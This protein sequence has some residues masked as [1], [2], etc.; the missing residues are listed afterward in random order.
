M[1]HP[2]FLLPLSLLLVHTCAR[3]DYHPT[4]NS[5]QTVSGD[6]VDGHLGNQHVYGTLT[7]STITGSNAY[8]Y[9]ASGGQTDNITVTHQGTLFLEPGGYADHTSV[10]SGGQLQINGSAE[11]AYV[12]N[13]GEIYINAG[14]NG[15]NDPAQGGQALNTTIGSGGVMVNR[16]GVDSFTVVEAGGELDTGWNEPYEIRDIA[17]SQNATIK[18][19]GMQQVTNGGTSESSLVE[20]GSTL[21]VSGIW[22]YDSVLDPAPS[23]WYYGTANGSVIYGEMQNLGGVDTSTTLQSGGKYLLDNY[24]VSRKLTVAQGG[25]AQINHGSLND[26][27]LYGLMNVSDD[28]ILTGSGTVG[29]SG[30][31]NLNEGAQTAGLDLML[32]G[33]LSLHNNSS[34]TPHQYQFA[35]LTLDGGTVWFDPASFATLST[36]TLTGNG[37]FYMNTDIASSQ[38]DMISVNGDARGDFGIAV[39]D[40]GVSPQEQSPLQI[41]H[42]D[43]GDA[44]FTLL[45][46]NQQVDLGTWKYSLTPDGQ[47]N[48]SLT[49]QSTPSPTP[50]TEA[51]LAMANVTPT[52]FQTEIDVLHRRLDTVRSLA[53]EGEFWMEALSNRFDVNRTGNAAYRQTLGGVM[54]GYDTHRMVANGILTLG[55]AGSYSRSNLDMTNNS[56]GTVDSY[57]TALYASYHDQRHF[58][59]EGVLKGNLFNQHLN[60]RMSSGGRADGSYTTPGI[61]GSL[62]TGIDILL[63]DTTL[64]PF[65]GVTGFTSQSDDYAL[66]NG[67]QAHPGTAKSALAQAGIRISQQ[68][69]TDNGAQ[70]T[71]WLK[72]TLEQEF[73]HSNEVRVNGDRFNSDI[74]GSRGSY[75]AGFSAVLTPQ[76]RLY[77]SV[78]YEKGEGMESPW[79]GS[80]GVSYAF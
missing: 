4:I 33:N 11:N 62:I 47:G 54:M 16:Y 31:L 7:D 8:S 17:I 14:E 6:V 2:L 68:I 35:S 73:V 37:N 32:A 34:A 55:L 78:K 42:T 56:E 77:A 74:A 44:Q 48:W 10:T 45:N 15:V 1:K 49:P 27:W 9:V 59:L 5:G 24:G 51:V 46:P 52:I 41:I 67:M 26:F 39:A 43:G 19:G 30:E 65:I 13:G 71:P 75:Q 3:A 50:S 64:S 21:I 40:T 63:A 70:L 69:S 20:T 72:V 53:H 60:A 61:G 58:W 76:T 80:M 18:S 57:S 66:S 36:D 22:H 38:G 79:T 29:N 23:A 12:D 25:S 28:A